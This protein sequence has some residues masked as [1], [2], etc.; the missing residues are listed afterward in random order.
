MFKLAVI[1][2]PEV[3]IERLHYVTLVT[4]V[5]NAHQISLF[6]C[7]VW[8]YSVDSRG[9]LGGGRGGEEKDAHK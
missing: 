1:N 4:S 5:L 6:I 3:R 8:T 7:V 9:G 2:T